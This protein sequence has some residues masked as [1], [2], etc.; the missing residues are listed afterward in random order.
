MVL[1][2]ADPRPEKATA[3]PAATNPPAMQYSTIVSP[4]SSCH[5]AVAVFFMFFIEISD[6][7][8]P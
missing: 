3:A 1:L 5:S 6:V 2:I 7:G 8:M 4:S